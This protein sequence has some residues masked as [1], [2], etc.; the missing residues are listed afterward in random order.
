MPRRRRS[1]DV[2]VASLAALALGA[3]ACEA[4]AGDAG[5][6]LV[7]QVTLPGTPLTLIPDARLD[8]VGGGYFLIGSD[9]SNVRWAALSA[10]GVLGPE[11]A[12]PLPPG[13]TS[14][15]FAMAGQE[16]PGDTV[17]VGYLAAD[18]EGNGT[19]QVIPVPADGSPPTATA[20]PVVSFPGGVPD[21]SS[22]VMVSSRAG[23][24]AGLAWVAG[25][26]TAA[27]VMV[28]GVAG[29]GVT[30]HDPVSTSLSAGPPF[31]CLGFSPGRDDLTVVYYATTTSLGSAGW[32][33]AEANEGGAVDSGTVLAFN[34][35]QGK[36]AVVTPTATGYGLVWEDNQG[37]W[38]AEYTTQGAVLSP[39]YP[40]AS[41]ASFGGA[42][43]EPPL[44]GL[45]PFGSDFG[46]LLS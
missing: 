21:A 45:A 30:T 23:M 41:A 37:G 31:S 4:D 14:A 5:C 7:A 3:G 26:A 12:F 46:V 38:L 22:V 44:V 10:D 17:V 18:G 2:V 15:T 29:T 34:R 13:V 1:H 42:D 27:Q 35:P 33:I 9:G 40:F 11:Q 19:L 24:N 28:T 43:L 39:L 16:T 20:A 6:Q 8:Q 25:D 36:C 32:V